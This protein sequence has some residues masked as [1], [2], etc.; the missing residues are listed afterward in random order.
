MLN[1]EVLPNVALMAICYAYILFVIFVST[2]LPRLIGA[3]QKTSRK[4]LHI[5]IGNLPLIMPFFTANIYPVLVAAPFI[6][7]TF[8]ASPYSPSEK[9]KKGLKGLTQVSEEG[10]Q[11]GLVFYAISYT[12]LAFLFASKTYIIA[13]GILPMAYGD[14]A[15]SIIG[16]KYGKRRYHLTAD[17]SLEGSAAMLIGSLLSFGASLILFSIL[18]SFSLLSKILLV[19]I[20]SIVVTAVEALSP[21]GFDNLTVP[22]LGSL[23]FALLNGGF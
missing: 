3:S 2:R 10:H 13:A 18:Y 4:F 20:T 17:K 22:I 8:L 7:V 14:S 1:D 23:T 6:L 15:A 12:L 19:F 9:A 11:L 21:M 16:E 5:M